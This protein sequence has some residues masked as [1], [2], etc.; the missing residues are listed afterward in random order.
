[1]YMT[2]IALTGRK[3]YRQISFRPFPVPEFPG[4]HRGIPQGAKGRLLGY[5]RVILFSLFIET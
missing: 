2:D 3:G 1:M 5:V 4:L